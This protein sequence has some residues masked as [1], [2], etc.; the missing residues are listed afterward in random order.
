MYYY[1][2]TPQPAALKN[3]EAGVA[4]GGGGGGGG[5]AAVAVA[6]WGRGGLRL[7]LGLGEGVG[8]G[9]RGGERGPKLGRLEPTLGVLKVAEE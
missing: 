1:P 2:L 7:R 6:V 4:G 5:A 3:P 9:L 8:F